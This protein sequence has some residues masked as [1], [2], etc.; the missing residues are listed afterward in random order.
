MEAGPTHIQKHG[1]GLINIFKNYDDLFKSTRELKSKNQE[2]A[3]K[4]QES[5]KKLKEEHAPC[6][7]ENCAAQASQLLKRRTGADV[8]CTEDG[9]DGRI[10]ATRYAGGNGTRKEAEKRNV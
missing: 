2:T 8:G 7:S 6:K 3:T 1:A 5:A 4:L 10:G 9:R